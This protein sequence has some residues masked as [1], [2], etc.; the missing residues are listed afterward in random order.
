MPGRVAP[1]RGNRSVREVATRS[2]HKGRRRRF[3]VENDGGGERGMGCE[4]YSR[5]DPRSVER[6]LRRAPRDRRLAAEDVGVE[7]LTDEMA[8]RVRPT[9]CNPNRM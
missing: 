6:Y 8:A 7:P 1:A 4:L 2:G 9:H 5:Q 3:L